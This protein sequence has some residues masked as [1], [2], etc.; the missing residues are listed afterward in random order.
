MSPALRRVASFGLDGA[1]PAEPFGLGAAAPAEPF[2]VEPE[3]WDGFL[4]VLGTG[5]LTGLASAAAA[6]GVLRLTDG[7]RQQL[8]AVHRH[9]M[10]LNLALEQQLL[11]VAAAFD[12]EGIEAVVLKGSAVARTCYPDPSWRPFKDL[13]LLVRTRDWERSCRLVAALGYARKL[14]E[15]RPGFD[16]RFGKAATHRS[17]GGFELDLHRRLVLGPFGLWMDP[18]PLLARTGTFE[19]AGRRLRRLGDTDLLLH[20]CM[21]ASLG[22]SPPLPIPVRDVVQIATSLAVDWDLLAGSASRWRLTAVL[23][24]ALATAAGTTGWQPCDEARRLMATAAGARERRA[25]R[26]YTSDRRGE[27]ATTLSA[28][29]AIPGVRPKLAYVSALACPS[30]AFLTARSAGGRTSY[31]ARWVVALRWLARRVARHDAGSSPVAPGK[32]I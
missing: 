10:R 5:S 2:D 17:A 26:A 6:A 23:A 18:E 25:L 14:E 11:A 15:P 29:A 22:W 13:D 31:L 28:L 7:Q 30:R 32:R 1:A 9:V 3:R 12:G 4:Q 21:H 16:E 8:A 19:L 24:H 20:A 27:G